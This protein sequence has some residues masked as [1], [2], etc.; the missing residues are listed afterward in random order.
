MFSVVSMHRTI[1][2]ICFFPHLFLE[3][4]SPASKLHI[5]FNHWLQ[6][7]ICSPPWSEPRYH[8]PNF[9]T[10]PH[11]HPEISVSRF[12]HTVRCE[13]E[14]RAHAHGAPHS[15]THSALDPPKSLQGPWDHR[16]LVPTP[17]SSPCWPLWPGGWSTRTATTS[18]S[19]APTTSPRSQSTGSPS[20]PSFAIRG[21][22]AGR[23]PAENPGEARRCQ[24]MLHLYSNN[25][26]GKGGK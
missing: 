12:H 4:F 25:H 8:S 1:L 24:A 19:L 5:G 3:S 14:A 2:R 21:R 9:S 17:T 15:G 20:L 18:P 16:C 10:L 26:T 13:A 23:G 6:P 7:F 11:A 22:P